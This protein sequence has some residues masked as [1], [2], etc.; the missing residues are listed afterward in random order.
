MNDSHT[1]HL[2]SAQVFSDYAK[3]D[4]VGTFKLGRGNVRSLYYDSV[5]N[6]EEL[7]NVRSPMIE[8]EVVNMFL[9]I[10][11]ISEKLSVGQPESEGTTEFFRYA[12][13]ELSDLVTLCDLT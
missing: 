7:L 5:E 12:A 13:S 1:S 11:K 10:S 3:D 9:S 6:I 8:S 2:Q 4:L